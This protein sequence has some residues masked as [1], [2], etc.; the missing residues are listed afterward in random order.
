MRHAIVTLMLFALAAGC[1]PAPTLAPVPP[2]S[3]EAPKA[4][5]A[6]PPGPQTSVKPLTIGVMPKLVGIDFFNATEKGAREAA[7]ELGVTIDYDGPTTNDVNVQSQMVETWI[8]KKYD[9]IAI[10]PNDPETIST[11]LSDARA[12]GIKVVSWDA[13]SRKDARDFFVNQC[14]PQSV[15]K[16]LMD[17]AA[18]G[19]SKD[20]KYVILTGSLTAANQNIWM[21]EMEKYRQAVYPGMTNLSPTPK[22]SEE[23]KALAMQVAADCLK[24]YPDMQA[25]FA[26]T[27][28]ALPGAAEAFRNSGP[29]VYNKV[30]LTGLSTPNMMREYVKQGV[31]K[32]F[33]L[34]S[35]VDL[36]YLAVQAAVA[37]A[38]GELTPTSTTLKAGRLGD[39]TVKDGEIVLGDPIIFDANNI[40]Q[41]NF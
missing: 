33:V 38:R 3:P 37:S 23:D 6:A 19:A 8:A 2:A 40:D 36:G 30:T 21:G 11:V 39:I 24:T 22:A 17:V 1:S 12:K 34:W 28:V 13:D 35:A 27:S 18:E 16:A 7:K 20:A 15:A 41:H 5:E 29:D 26:I 4:P 9:A 32:K 25:L 31:V 14:T 10:A